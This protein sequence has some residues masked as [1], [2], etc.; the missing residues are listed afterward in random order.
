[1][2]ASH[3]SAVAGAMA[4]C[5]VLQINSRQAE[6]GRWAAAEGGKRRVEPDRVCSLTCDLDQSTRC[7][8]CWS[9]GQQQGRQGGTR[10]ATTLA[11][12][13]ETGLR[14]A[15]NWREWT[16]RTQRWIERGSPVPTGEVHAGSPMNPTLP[17]FAQR[18]SCSGYQPPSESRR[19]HRKQGAM[20]VSL[21]PLRLPAFVHE[22]EETLR[23]RPPI[24]APAG[25]TT[26]GGSGGGVGR[27]AAACSP[28]VAGAL[29]S[30][31]EPAIRLPRWPHVLAACRTRRASPSRVRPP[32]PGRPRSRSRCGFP[33][34]RPEG[35]GRAG[36]WG[37]AKQLPWA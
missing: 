25:R 37:Q 18:S 1:M 34:G 26:D 20:A 9:E 36:W 3:R 2:C 31:L 5:F 33:P 11:S 27:A 35:A 32:S 21:Q 12:A 28:H 30:L 17:S 16:R 10:A 13:Q 29:H 23:S 7:G 6:G 14:D 22:A 8:M 4:C 19:E 24:A 15:P